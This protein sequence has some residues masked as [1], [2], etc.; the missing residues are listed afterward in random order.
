MPP[1]PRCPVMLY[2]P[3]WVPITRVTYGRRPGSRS[4]AVHG[5]DVRLRPALL[6]LFLR[7]L[8]R[9]LA[10]GLLVARLLA[11]GLL[12]AGFLA[13]GLLAARLLTRFLCGHSFSFQ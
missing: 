3:I 11:A 10:A 5:D 4:F 7:R 12:A 6:R 2:E 9:L 1:D 8:R 13:A